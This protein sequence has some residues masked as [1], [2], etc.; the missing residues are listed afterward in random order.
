MTVDIIEV[1]LSGV[2]EDVDQ[3][4][5]VLSE[6]EGW[7]ADDLERQVIGQYL[8]S[9]RP[10]HR[11]HTRA[12]VAVACEVADC[13]ELPLEELA[14]HLPFERYEDLGAAHLGC[15][16]VASGRGKPLL[17]PAKVWAEFVQ[18]AARSLLLA[19]SDCDPD[20]ALIMLTGARVRLY[21][22]AA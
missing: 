12:L 17:W 21:Q 16:R 20:V 18:H 8:A 9:R 15:K 13:A 11:E 19:A 7:F 5:L 3:A 6:L 10:R 4:H 1:D 22:G 14:L 2:P